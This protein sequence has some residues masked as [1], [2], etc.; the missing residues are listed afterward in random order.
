MYSFFA[1][2][3][4]GSDPGWVEQPIEVE[5]LQALTWFRG[6]G[7]AP[8]FGSDEEFFEAFK[9]ERSERVALLPVEEKRTMLAWAT[10][11][12]DEKPVMADG[13]FVDADGVTIEKNIV[14]ATRGQQ[15]PFVR[16]IPADWD[17]R[18]VCL[19]LGD[20]K[21]CVENEAVRRKLEE[22]VAVV[23]GDLFL[24]GE[25]AGEEKQI[26]GDEVAQRHFTTFHYTTDAY[27]VQD[28]ALLW[29]AAT[30]GA[31]ECTLW[32]EKT[33]ARAAACALPLLNTLKKAELEKAA[34][35]L[36]GDEAYYQEFFVPGIL[37][38][39]GFEGCMKMA[40]C[41]VDLF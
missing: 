22:G 9:Q 6:E 23:S 26:A 29:K 19:A 21:D 34:L 38:L 4:L 41:E 37:L 18:R 11:I 33:A 15:I 7:H 1:R 35:E 5:D 8:G 25:M 10:G 32:A 13:D 20:G 12:G 3:L 17:G 40:G 30:E 39:G 24:T 27:R 28:V 14:T 31:E 2:H 16:L 36:S